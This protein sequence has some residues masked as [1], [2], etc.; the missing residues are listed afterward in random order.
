[1][2]FLVECAVAGI[3]S[4]RP[5]LNTPIKLTGAQER[6]IGTK[7]FPVAMKLPIKFETSGFD[8]AIG[9]SVYAFDRCVHRTSLTF[10]LLA[11]I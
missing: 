6:T 5:D 7:P 11:H 8:H 3:G 2:C 10:S 4:P 9:E 1:M